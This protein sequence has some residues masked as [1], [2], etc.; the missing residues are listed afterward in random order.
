VNCRRRMPDLNSRARE[1]LIRQ[2]HEHLAFLTSGAFNPGLIRIFISVPTYA[3]HIDPSP[4]AWR[5]NQVGLHDVTASHVCGGLL[6][7]VASDLLAAALR[8]Q[9]VFG[10]VPE[11]AK[12]SNIR[13]AFL[14]GTQRL[15]QLRKCSEVIFQTQR[16]GAGETENRVA[17]RPQFARCYG[18][19]P[20]DG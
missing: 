15:Q 18:L 9:R 2:A 6:L 19:K 10:K 5:E 14:A 20:A 7:S 16:R 3:S 12:P 1:S 8:R 13:Y 17:S 11:V 4:T